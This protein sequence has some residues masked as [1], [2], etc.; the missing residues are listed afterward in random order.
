M[1]SRGKIG[2]VDKHSYTMSEC[3]DHC[4]LVSPGKSCVGVRVAKLGLVGE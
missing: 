1:R 4:G 3:D 2:D